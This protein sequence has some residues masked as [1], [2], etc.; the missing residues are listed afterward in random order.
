MYVVAYET[1][2]EIYHAKPICYVCNGRLFSLSSEIS[3]KFLNIIA[4]MNGNPLDS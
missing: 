4:E 3:N 2:S 1:S